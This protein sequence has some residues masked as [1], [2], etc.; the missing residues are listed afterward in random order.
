MNPSRLPAVIFITLLS[1]LLA[2]GV[3]AAGSRIAAELPELN[4]VGAYQL[5]WFDPPTGDGPWVVRAHYDDRSLVNQVITRLVPWEVHHDKGY[6]VLMVDRE[7]YQ[8]LLS[9]GFQLEIDQ[10]L[11]EQVNQVAAP[12]PGQ[13]S[14]IP[15]YACYR[16]VEETYTTAQ[17]LVSSY[18]S[19]AVWVDVGD[20]WE[21][22]TPGGSPGYDLQVLRLTQVSVP[23]PKP[24]LFV[25]SSI[26]A[27]EYTPAELITRFAEYLLA[28]YDVDPDVTW[29]L[30]YHE[31]HLLL[32][33]NPDGRKQAETGLSWRKNTDNNYCSNSNNR[34]VDLNRNFGFQW[35]CCG[36]SSS[37]V[38]SESYR[39]PSPASEPE[40]QAIQ[41]YVRSQFPDQRADPLTSPA[42]EDATGVFL[43]I[44]SYSQL[45]LWPWGF[46]STPAPNATAL[47]TLGRKF[48]YFNAYLPQQAVEL[49]PTDGTTDD[50]AY[51]ELG[52]AAYTFELGTS[53]FQ[54]CASFE[55]T[56]LPKNLAALL[57]A[58][59]VARTPY[60]TP[61]GPEVLEVTASP[62]GVAPGL[63]IQLTALAD[64]TRFS[65]ANGVE[66]T[67]NISAA[68]YYLD[69]PPWNPTPP[70]PYSLNPA[71]GSLD[72][73]VESLI[74]SI[75][76]SGL[77]QGRH[78]VFVRA[79]D[80]AGNWGP[81]SAAFIYILDPAIAPTLQGYIREYGTRI[82]LQ[83]T[84]QAGPFQTLS[85]PASGFYNMLVI[86]GTYEVNAIAPGHAAS[87]NPSTLARDYQVT[88]L[89]FN[90]YPLCNVFEDDLELGNIGWTAQGSWAISTEASHSPTH[91]WSDSPGGGYAN[92]LNISLISPIM[93]LSGF[94][95]SSLSFWHTY[96]LESRYD[97][98]YVEYS[99]DGGTL[100]NPVVEYSG[101]QSSWSRVEISLPALDGMAD[102]RLR[103]RLKTDWT[104][105]RDGWHIDD[106]TLAG[107]GTACI[108][109]YP[110][111]LPVL[112]KP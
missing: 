101:Q 23:G 89:N 107:G 35:G 81:V 65:S 14:G 34:G 58:A 9:L 55:N 12:L 26:H 104:V 44:H 11:T 57:Y 8:W 80:T 76:T 38:C 17:N 32:Q 45:V 27:R 25:M 86:S 78:T 64:D 13:L 36:G 60:L 49:Y 63:P 71:D 103:F 47:Q 20:T 16:T 43:D 88:D 106:I 87:T 105:Q 39:G 96:D 90:L 21:K 22:I 6:L 100:W 72:A 110:L 102:V 41:N 42:P 18:P 67:Q 31:I 92:N 7:Q 30:D 19:L 33:A 109:N 24:K 4:P 15:G 94:V 50:F 85:D 29:L 48:A 62:V 5:A 53:F 28:N 75:D 37:F 111:W 54:D 61:A 112:A 84:I 73:P 77:S 79:R 3:L 95:D 56:I 10:D 83:A 93:D 2:G 68:E 1:L 99:T 74:A 91:A 70:A 51:G 108:S 82:P 66:P 52:L 46:T 59:K 98:A 69:T 40:T 97:Y